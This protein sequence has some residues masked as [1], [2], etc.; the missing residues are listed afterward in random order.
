MKPASH[1][2]HETRLIG[3]PANWNPET[4]GP[5]GALSICDLPDDRGHNCMISRWELED[6][7]LEKLQG[8]APIFLSILGQVHP[9]VCVYLGDP[10]SPEAAEVEE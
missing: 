9:V 6:G 4:D 10:P 3:A 5:C 2:E 8:G 7:D 1:G